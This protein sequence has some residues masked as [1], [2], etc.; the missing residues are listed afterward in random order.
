M[1]TLGAGGEEA[2]PS[3]KPGLVFQVWAF[4]CWIGATIFGSLSSMIARQQ[5]YCIS[6]GLVLWAAC[7]PAPDPSA[8]RAKAPVQ[9]QTKA[10]SPGYAAAETGQ[11]ANDSVDVYEILKDWD[12][13]DSKRNRRV[14]PKEICALSLA[15]DMFGFGTDQVGFVGR[16]SLWLPGLKRPGE[17]YRKYVGE[18]CSHA[19]ESILLVV[20]TVIEAPIAC[21]LVYFDFQTDSTFLSIKW[22]LG[23]CYP[24][25]DILKNIQNKKR[26]VSPSNK[27]YRRTIR[28]CE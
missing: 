22:K 17:K 28:Y 4:S 25:R 14:S 23:N 18:K 27:F 11:Q 15:W 3:Q 1:V 2:A 9:S 19:N 5:I 26:I 8:S 13:K 20:E 21:N 10:T 24:E 6:L 7:K 12:I 16:D